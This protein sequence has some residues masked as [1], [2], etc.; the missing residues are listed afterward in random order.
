VR[1]TR[2]SPAATPSSQPELVATSPDLAS[3]ARKIDRVVH[4][5]KSE[6]M[7]KAVGMEGKK[8][9]TDQIR[10]D[11]GG[12]ARMTNW[13]R[14]RPINLTPRFDIKSDTSVEIAPPGRAR[15]P[16]RVLTDGRQAGTSRRGRPVSSSRGKGTWS[17]A[18]A[19]MEQ[20]LPKV[21]AKHVE[22]VLRKH[23]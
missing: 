10:S 6:A 19:E 16:V 7:L 22:T 14:G 8:I 1:G 11:T 23:F 20:Q 5:L 2:R 3:L 18:A 4:D 9:G 21:A 17:A 15:G 13:R 12:D